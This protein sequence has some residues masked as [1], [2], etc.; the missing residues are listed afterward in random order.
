MRLLAA[1]LIALLSFPA[2]AGAPAERE[3][4]TLHVADGIDLQVVELGRADAGKP[5]VVVLHGGPGGSFEALLPLV[6]PL[7][8][9]QRIVLFDQRGS[10]HS[11]APPEAIGFEAMVEDIERLRVQLDAPRIVL[12][13]HSMGSLLA[14]AYAKAHPQR[15]ERMILVAPQ[16]PLSAASLHQALGLPAPDAGAAR[17]AQQRNQQR[18]QAAVAAERKRQRLPDTPRNDLERSRLARIDYAAWSIHDL[19]RWREVRFDAAIYNNRNVFRRW[20]ESDG[21]MAAF[22]ARRDTWWPAL[23]ALDVPMTFIVG[24]AD[25]NTDTAFWPV[26]VKRLPQA[27]LATIAGAGHMPWIDQP[28]RVQAAMRLP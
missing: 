27:R 16:F 19:S 1:L 24:D 7:V 14:Y 26:L 17:A 10:L 20:V 5:P 4:W 11:P 23:Q 21:S 8:T 28:V 13:S 25:M 18:V 22:D 3:R 2:V 15:I 6:A 12:L 9:Q